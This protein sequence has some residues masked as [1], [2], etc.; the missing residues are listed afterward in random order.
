MLRASIG[1]QAVNAFT[2]HR[3]DLTDHEIVSVPARLLALSRFFMNRW[4]RSVSRQEDAKGCTLANSALR[5]DV[6]AA[7]PNDAV[8]RGQT[9]TAV[10]FLGGEKRLENARLGFVA[11]SVPVIGHCNN[12]VIAGRQIRPEAGWYGVGPDLEGRSGNR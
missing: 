7:L 8:A 5:T 10:R 12:D 9:E 3:P 6:T 4:R 1:R 2:N 11:H